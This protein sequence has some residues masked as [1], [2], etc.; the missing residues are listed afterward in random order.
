MAKQEIGVSEHV[1][2]QEHD[3]GYKGILSDKAEFLHFITK[4]FPEL[5]KAGVTLDDVEK[6]PNSFITEEFRH[7]DSD[8]VYRIKLRGIDVYFYVLLELQSSVDFTMV[9]RLLRYMVGLL[10]FLFNNTEE[11]VRKRKEFRL[12]AVVPIVLY[13]GDD[14]WT[15]VRRFR[16]YTEHYNIFGDSI[17]DFSYHL[18]DLK[19]MDE[20]TILSTRRLIDIIF[21][22]DK[23]L[24]RKTLKSEGL[25][26]ISE[27]L[28]SIAV[29][30]TPE[31]R[32]KMSCWIAHKG[33][34]PDMIE[35]ILEHIEQ[36]SRKGDGSAMKHGLD[37]LIE[38][39]QSEGFERGI[40]RGMERGI[41]R[42]RET[43]ARKMIEL[44][45]SVDE[46]VEITGLTVDDVLRLESE[47]L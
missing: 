30:L 10:A 44:G 18:F 6:M 25:D 33:V 38:E 36:P 40:E 21:L 29:S 4:Y 47:G 1:R 34:S 16:E 26:A 5:L 22:L 46:I 23:V 43:V 8:I 20:E 17:I 28:A 31:E 27:H 39:W 24:N 13:N 15:A 19:R 45:K 32:S 37:E 3:T 7:L 9:F 11:K 14:S 2:P 12:P 42:E 41:Q 35:K